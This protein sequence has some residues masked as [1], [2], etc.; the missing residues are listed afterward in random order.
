MIEL[1][2]RAQ[3]LQNLYVLYIVRGGTIMIVTLFDVLI[4]LA[5]LGI[6]YLWLPQ[7]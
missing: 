7:K 6:I 5:Y 1:K 2:L 4:S 3:V